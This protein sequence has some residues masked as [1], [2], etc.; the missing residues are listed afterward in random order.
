MLIQGTPTQTLTIGKVNLTLPFETDSTARL[1]ELKLTKSSG[2]FITDNGT[3]YLE[4][5]LTVSTGETA[6]PEVKVTDRFTT[7]AKYIAEYLGVSEAVK[8]LGSTAA[9]DGTP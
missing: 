7:N 4:Y 1:G 5:T 8:Q 9:S 6:M 3:S 2:T